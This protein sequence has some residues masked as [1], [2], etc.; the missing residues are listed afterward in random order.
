[1]KKNKKIK[2]L[3]QF[4]LGPLLIGS[5]ISLGYCVAKRM[6]NANKNPNQMNGNSLNKQTTRNK[7]SNE[8]KFYT[9]LK[10]EINDPNLIK[11]SKILNTQ[12][13]A[14]TN[15]SE[16]LGFSHTS[17]QTKHSLEKE[18]QKV[19]K[20]KLYEKPTK[21]KLLT[22]AEKDEGLIL[23]LP[24]DPQSL[25]TELFFKKHKIDELLKS[26]PKIRITPKSSK[27]N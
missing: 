18:Q 15:S 22:P 25:E 14:N 27:I 3:F 19:I 11:K 26:L 5:S 24:K 16:T 4:W 13:K 23:T 1:M 7:E 10:Q 9:E 20:Q 17:K 21:N 2:R 12:E 8:P 6:L